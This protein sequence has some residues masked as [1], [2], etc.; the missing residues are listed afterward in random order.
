MT[1]E[2]S[3]G[4]IKAK[5]SVWLDSKPPLSGSKKATSNFLLHLKRKHPADATEF[6][7]SKRARQDDSQKEK[8]PK[9]M[10]T[11]IFQF[12]KS[13]KVTQDAASKAI[14]NLLVKCGLA[15]SL[16]EAE[17]F[18][19]IVST[20]SSG[21]Y[22]S[23]S[24]KS[25]SVKIDKQFEAV[26]INI[27]KALSLKDY[28]CTTTDIWSQRKR[29]FLDMTAH[30]VDPETLLRESFAIAC[31]KF[32]GTHSFDSIAEKIQEVHDKIG[33]DYKKITRTITDNASNFAKAFRE[34]GFK[35]QNEN[36]N[37]ESS[38]DKVNFESINGR[39]T[40]T[41]KNDEELFVLPTQER[42]FAHIGEMWHQS[43][44]DVFPPSR[45]LFI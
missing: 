17:P 42:C 34:F 16:V 1:E 40:F 20:L 21:T 28:V 41:C 36:D 23:I 15:L 37:Q 27:K 24:R 18:Q 3:D 4:K 26:M 22:K 31:E 9:T 2:S 12:C 39:V 10:Q 33:L 44:S 45:G 30:V 6:E 43:D 25:L 13:K 5:C 19:Q 38:E 11:T 35:E 32:S 7:K 14:V 29:S 8:T